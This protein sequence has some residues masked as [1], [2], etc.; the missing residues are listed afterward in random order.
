M[1]YLGVRLCLSD[2]QLVRYAAKLLIV[3]RYSCAVI[4]RVY[5]HTA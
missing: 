3:L 4:Y 1:E 5:Q 2:I